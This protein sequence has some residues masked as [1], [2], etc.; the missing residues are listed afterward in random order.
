MRAAFLNDGS[1]I[2]HIRDRTQTGHR[3]ATQGFD[4]HTKSHILFGRDANAHLPSNITLHWEKSNT[5]NFLT[6]RRN[7]INPQI[8]VFCSSVYFL[9]EIR[10]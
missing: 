10:H 2:A 8:C 7:L 4:L 3:T 9:L 5:R 6:N 1:H